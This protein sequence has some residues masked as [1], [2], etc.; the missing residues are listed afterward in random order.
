MTTLPWPLLDS[1][2][3]LLASIG[4]VTPQNAVV[5]VRRWGLVCGL[6]WRSSG[7]SVSAIAANDPYSNVPVV[8]EVEGCFSRQQPP[9]SV[10][11]GRVEDVLA[12]TSTTAAHGFCGGQQFERREAGF[13]GRRR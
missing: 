11:T 6:S 8:S 13:E 2:S 12:T 1:T 3:S 7:R 4:V 10:V 5:A 9:L